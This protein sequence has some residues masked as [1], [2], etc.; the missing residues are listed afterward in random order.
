MSHVTLKAGNSIVTL[1]PDVGGGISELVLASHK[2]LLRERSV[3]P[4]DTD[5][6]N[7][8]EFPMGP[9]VNRIANGRFAWQEREICVADGPGHDPQ[10]LHG[11]GW[12]RSWSISDRSETEATLGVTWTG[13]AGWP[14]PFNFTRRFILEPRALKIEARLT[15][16]GSQPMP[17][18]IGFHPYFPTRGA[19]VRANTSAG[20]LTDRMGLP[21]FLGLED[22][23]ARMRSGLVIADEPLDNCFVGWDG[24]AEIEWPTHTLTMRTEPALRYLQVYSPANEDRFCVEPQSAI[25]DAF[26]RDP[27]TSGVCVLP[28][29]ADLS[30][31]LHFN[32]TPTVK[33]ERL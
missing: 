32:I 18:A 3:D 2:I 33:T 1:A 11:I 28:P 24:V 19:V 29:G 6:R 23:A 21:A 20:W 8:G 22:I 9:W 5:P 13:G 4:H 26:N 14:F 16:L 27:A 15:N 12:R 7:L 25:P 17:S 31:S 10:G 30:E